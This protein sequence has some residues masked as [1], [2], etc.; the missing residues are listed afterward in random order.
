MMK[1]LPDQHVRLS[2]IVEITEAK[3]SANPKAL[4]IDLLPQNWFWVF[5]LKLPLLIIIFF[6]ERPEF[7]FIPFAGCDRYIHKPGGYIGSQTNLT[8]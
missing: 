6:P 7:L 4:C 1:N 8:F 5:R 2:I 3:I